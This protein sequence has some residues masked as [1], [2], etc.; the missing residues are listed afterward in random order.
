MLRFYVA[1]D[2]DINTGFDQYSMNLLYLVP[3]LAVLCL[4]PI[5]FISAQT[6]PIPSWIRNNAGLWADEVIGD[7]TFLAGIEF[8]IEN[9]IIKVGTIQELEEENERLRNEL[10]SL[11]SSAPTQTMEHGG[12][13]GWMNHNDH[14]WFEVSTFVTPWKEFEFESTERW[15][16]ERSKQN[17]YAHIIVNVDGYDQEALVKVGVLTQQNIDN[18]LMFSLA[19]S[20]LG[21]VAL[22]ELV[23]EEAGH[24]L[25]GDVT[26][27]RLLTV[28][29]VGITV[30]DEGDDKGR[31]GVFFLI[32]QIDDFYFVMFG[33]GYEE[34]LDEIRDIVEMNGLLT[35]T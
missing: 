17:E 8:L 2:T 18:D 28:D 30:Y 33:D 16:L 24:L 22:E 10:W 19:F 35:K 5:G 31:Y 26:V 11:Q 15:V 29:T 7:E 25:L 13:F 14:D 23:M 6:E 34:A 21:L 27:E 9:G 1:P 4:V 12:L 32:H 3:A 20:K